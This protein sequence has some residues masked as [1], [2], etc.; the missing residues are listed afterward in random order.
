MTES[1]VHRLLASERRRLALDVLADRE[2]ASLEDLAAA[3]A[4]R[5]RPGGATRSDLRSVEIEL[6]HR[7][8]PLMAELGAVDFDREARRVELREAGARMG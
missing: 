3:V 4:D 8:L 5:G 1:D 2:R 6:F 7:H